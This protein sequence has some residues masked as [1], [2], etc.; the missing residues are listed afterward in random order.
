MKMGDKIFVDTNILLR[1]TLEAYPNHN[2]L[3]TYVTGFIQAGHELWISRQVLREYM[4]QAT[5]PQNFSQPLTIEQIETQFETIKT[6]F[7]IADETQAVTNELVRL[8]KTYP[9]GGRQI[10]DANI[11]ATMVV[12]GLTHLMTLN[13]ED[14]RR[15]VDEIT[16]LSPE[17]T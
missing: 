7:Q 3:K 4:A 1:A 16:I 13:V 5:R 12:Q 6:V 17:I 11:V 9:S 15:F 14:F 10:H 8:V 2:A